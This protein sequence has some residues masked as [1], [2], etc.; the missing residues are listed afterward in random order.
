MA[1]MSNYLG[2]LVC[3]EF[4]RERPVTVTALRLGTLVNEEETDGL[5]PDPAWLDYRDAAQAFVCAL[6]RDTSGELL[7][8]RRW[9]LYHVCAD[10]PNPRFLIEPAR[11]LGYQ[12]VHNFVRHWPVREG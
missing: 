3:R 4:A 6:R 8:I 7:W 5:A 2:E 10:I 9:G 11:Q 1:E 12:P